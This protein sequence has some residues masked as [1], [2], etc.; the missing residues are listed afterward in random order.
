MT[1]KYLLGVLFASGVALVAILLMIGK[2]PVTYVT[3]GV[4]VAYVVAAIVGASAT[5]LRQHRYRFVGMVFGAGLAFPGIAILYLTAGL[6]EFPPSLQDLLLMT[7]FTTTALGLP[8]GSADTR[9]RYGIV[10]GLMGVALLPLAGNVLAELLGPTY[11]GTSPVTFSILRAILTLGVVVLAL[12]PTYRLG[13]A[14][15]RDD[16]QSKRGTSNA[17]RTE[18]ESM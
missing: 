14:L 10:V 17:T 1:T 7:G 6:T 8:L 13:A 12:Y 2:H 16:Q 4:G 11:P 9:Q 15:H 5:Q 3:G 18:G